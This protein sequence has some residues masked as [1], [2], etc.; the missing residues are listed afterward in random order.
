MTINL[1]AWSSPK[2]GSEAPGQPSTDPWSVNQ[3]DMNE[4][5]ANWA[6]FSSASFGAFDNRENRIGNNVKVDSVDN[7][8]DGKCNVEAKTKSEE[9]INMID[10]KKEVA[11]GDQGEASR[12][13]TV[14]DVKVVQL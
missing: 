8:K 4:T 14:V 9:I 13:S 11:A 2:E 1:V 10:G 7:K 12:H 3:I 6:D 5:N